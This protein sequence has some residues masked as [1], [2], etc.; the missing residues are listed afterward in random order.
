MEAYPASF[1]QPH[2]GQ[3]YNLI[4]KKGDQS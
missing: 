4:A 3:F 1:I 2:G